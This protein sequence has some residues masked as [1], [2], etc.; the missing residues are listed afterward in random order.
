MIRAREWLPEVGCATFETFLR[1]RFH[2]V[3]GLGH[4]NNAVY[5]NYLEQA[6]ID[7]ATLLGLDEARL[8][9]LGGTF[10][11]R[12]H[13]IDY[14]RPALGGDALRVVTWL[15]E[16]Q[17]ARVERRYLVFLAPDTAV[18]A[19]L[20]G[21]LICED[22]AAAGELVVRA[23]T[24]WVFVSSAGRPRRVPEEVEALFRDTTRD[25]SGL[26]RGLTRR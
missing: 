7:H 8:R 6:A 4:V 3:D 9:G 19:P 5:L 26:A 1:V 25:T 16:S 18:P 10:V 22:E 20:G 24:E 12:R 15:G 14:I 17:G 2:E 11:A 23:K 21:R 13:E